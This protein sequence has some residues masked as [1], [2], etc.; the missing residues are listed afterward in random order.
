MTMNLKF[1]KMHGLGNDF[2][3][4]DMRLQKFNL[5]QEKIRYISDRKIGVGCDQVI[6]IESPS[7][8][9]CDCKML[10]YNADGSRVEACGNATRCVADIIIRAKDKNTALIE[11]DAGLLEAE[12]TSDGNFKVNMGTPSFD[13][14]SIPLSREIDTMSI[15]IDIRAKHE[16]LSEGI[17]VNIGNPHLLIFTQKPETIMEIE[18]YGSNLENDSLFPEKMNVSFAHIHKKNEIHIKTWERGVGITDACGSAACAAFAAVYKK[19]IISDTESYV[20]SKG[21]SLLISCG[22][23]LNKVLMTGPSTLVFSGHIP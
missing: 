9:N 15:P 1:I 7:A 8:K 18:K 11:T 2:V 5:P 3:I 6:V 16:T 20:V 10:I 14:R 13:W 21:G 17:A 19:G 4:I 22:E 23:N 12:R